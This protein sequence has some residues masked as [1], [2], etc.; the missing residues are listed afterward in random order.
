MHASTRF[1][2]ILLAAG[3]L[4]VACAQ[5]GSW[6]A[7]ASANW[8][9]ASRWEGG[10][11]A[12]G[13]DAVAYFTNSISASR[14]VT[15]D[16][17]VSPL[18]L[19][20]LQFGPTASNFGWTV[21]AGTLNATVAS[22]TPV[23][24]V[25][26]NTATIGSLLAGTQ[27]FVKQGPGV[28]RLTAANDIS[29]AITANGG[30]LRPAH[31]G[32][33]RS[34]TTLTVTNGAQL[35]LETAGIQQAAPITLSGQGPDG[36]GAF[37]FGTGNYTWTN[38]VTIAGTT[39]IGGYSGGGAL[40][41][42]GDISGSGDLTF[43]AGG[44]QTTHV[45]RFILAATNTFA[46]NVTLDATFGASTVLQ[47]SNSEL[48]PS[49]STLAMN[50]NWNNN[51]GTLDLGGFTQTLAGINFNNSRQKIISSTTATPALLVITNNLDCNGGQVLVSN[52]A[53]NLSAASGEHCF[54]DGA[55]VMTLVNS[56]LTSSYVRV[57][58]GTSQTGT[59]ILA[60]SSV[61]AFAEFMPGAPGGT[62]GGTVFVQSNSVVSAYRIRIVDTAS[63]GTLI[64][65]G[66]TVQAD[67]FGRSGGFT[68]VHGRIHL[69]GGRLQAAAGAA[70]AWM[71]MTQMVVYVRDGGAVIDVATGKLVNLS[72]P[73]RADTGSTGGVTK[74][75]QG[76]LACSASDN[77]N[78]SFTGGFRLQEGVLRAWSDG[79]LGAVPV[80]LQSEGV[81]LDGGGLKNNGR[82]LALSAN[83]G[84]TITTSNGYLTAGWAPTNPLSLGGPIAGP[85][86]LLV[87]LDGSPII[88]SNAAND[89]A[90]GLCIG[91]NGPGFYA[92]GAAAWLKLGASEVI[93]HGPGK[94]DVVVDGSFKG[95]LDLNGQTETINGLW[96]DGQIF[97]YSSDPATL[98]AGANDAAGRFDGAVASGGTNTITLVKTGTNTLT[99]AGN[100]D[101]TSLSLIVSN[102][103]VVLEKTNGSARAVGSGLRIAGGV[104]L[105]GSASAGDQI[106]Q[107]VSPVVDQGA[108]DLNG[109]AESFDGLNGTG[110][111]VTC[112]ALGGASTL[113]L[114]ENNG[115]GDFGGTLADGLG[116][117]SVVKIGSGTQQLSGT[118][119]Y[120][121]V[122][123]LV[124]AGSVLV[125][126]LNAGT[127]MVIVAGGSLGGHG[128]IAGHVQNAGQVLPGASIGRLAVGTY[129][130]SS[131]GQLLID[132]AGTI[133]GTSYDQLASAGPVSVDG[134]L[135]VTTNGYAPLI[136]DTFLVVTGTSVSGTFATTNLPA[137]PTNMAW[138]VSYSASAVTLQVLGSAPAPYDQW[139]ALHGIGPGQEEADT[140]GDGSV[141]LLE[142]ATGGSP[143]NSDTVAQLAASRLAGVLQLQFNRATNA[144]DITCIVEGAFTAANEATWTGLATNYAGSWGAATNV[145]ETGLGSPRSVT[146]TDSVTGA[147]N[148]FLRLR[149][150]KP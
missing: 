73:L 24:F 78:S 79:S 129:E 103:T 139:L 149:V 132:L 77:T 65:Q 36:R 13:L 59:L 43:W 20:G 121:G 1:I 9:D 21:A 127:G 142:Y 40:T 101:N 119:T 99:L 64:I 144:V 53:I 5:S 118:N 70:T 97:N 54:I 86:R 82:P 111:V 88:L 16:G 150:T 2:A 102:G 143:T 35:Y 108:L 105:I 87:N 52:V 81:T 83:R 93:P 55:T 38:P 57:G 12:T 29:G 34:A 17:A 14:T 104:V 107:A 28:L 32:A 117:L 39:R 25:S 120:Q 115:S 41:L 18:D 128:T 27:G 80:T 62:I 145:A 92:L 125:N 134:T 51:Y 133:P 19:G 114:G 26:N 67:D 44:A 89:W 58:G 116:S 126:G 22:G 91:T 94:G 135:T 136:G 98:T 148:R 76:E 45:Q 113:T 146:V 42:R 50:I 7:D 131:A 49:N 106:W 96:G 69:D 85:G 46:A 47:W 66:G 138:N 48:L 147:T 75:G 30:Y 11:M 141:N 23:F 10:V 72:L 122:T 71:T 109:M 112:G 31:L 95:L 124:G 137:L 68:N 123:L 4:R 15:L 61:R 8:S 110:G 33:L 37:Q 140:D 100:P 60:N 3:S 90:G 84:V 56:S 130:Q 74:T 63:A 6:N